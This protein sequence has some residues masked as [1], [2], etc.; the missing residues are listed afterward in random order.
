VAN[1]DGVELEIGGQR[2]RVVPVAGGAVAPT[3]QRTDSLARELVRGMLG[4]NAAPTLEVERGP[5]VGAKRALAPPDSVLVIGRGDDATW[6]ILDEDLS[7]AHAEV[8]R[9][10]DGTRIVDLGSKNGTKVDGVAVG[11]GGAELRDGATIE[12]GKVTIR[13]RDP[14]E[15]HLRG[16]PAK[17]RS[18]VSPP[19]ARSEP[20][21]NAVVFY[22]ALAIMA[23]ALAGLAWV[24]M[25]S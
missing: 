15:S 22:A 23:L 1:D 11:E 7:K 25:L 8:R 5:V 2:V 19:V 3:P 16:E 10:W 14:A 9:G 13:F 4:A 20:A 12:L 6:V 24:A 17:P 18:N 21:R